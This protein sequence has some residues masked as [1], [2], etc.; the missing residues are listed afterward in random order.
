MG[1]QGC[2][3]WWHGWGLCWGPSSQPT[4][5]FSTPSTSQLTCLC[6]ERRGVKPGSRQ[7]WNTKTLEILIRKFPWEELYHLP[8]SPWRWPR[9]AL[10]RPWYSLLLPASFWVPARAK[11]HYLWSGEIFA[12][13]TIFL[14]FLLDLSSV[15]HC[16]RMK[17]KVKT[18]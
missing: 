17:L 16:L 9:W 10:W 8:M 18:L 15:V 4:I 6:S 12:A 13:S 14:F 2:R 11:P 7:A 5:S 1:V 3:G